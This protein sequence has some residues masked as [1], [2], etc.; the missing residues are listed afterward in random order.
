ML[1]EVMLLNAALP[2]SVRD[3]LVHHLHITGVRVLAEL[4]EDVQAT[5]KKGYGALTAA[6]CPARQRKSRN[7]PVI[8][9]GVSE[10]CSR[11]S[12]LTG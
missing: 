6:G 8:S 12:S 3:V 9:T 4:Q 11:S 7:A 10:T 5:H 1:P 2:M